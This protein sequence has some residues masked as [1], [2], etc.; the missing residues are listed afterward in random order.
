MQVEL[1]G[2][3]KRF[4]P[5]LALDRVTA[6]IGPGEIVALIGLNG[7]GKTTLLRAL[8]G[9]VAPSAGEVR[10]EGERYSREQLERRKQIVFLPDF[11]PLFGDRTVLWHVRMVAELHG[12]PLDE[13]LADLVVELLERFDLTPLIDAPAATFSRGQ[14]YK[15]ALVAALAA[16]P[17]LW[18]LDEPFASGMDPRG[19]SELKARLR[20][21]V[22]AGATVLYTTQILEIAEKFADRLLVLDRGKLVQSYTRTEMAALPAAGPGSLEERLGQFREPVA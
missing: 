6:A 5:V 12:R 7:A 11:P 21:A 22:A 1:V 16:A 14:L 18:L 3:T 13:A 4:G 20:A 17:R 8:A 9:I 2:V 10:L 19:L 15:G